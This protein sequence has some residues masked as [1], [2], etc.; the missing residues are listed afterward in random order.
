MRQVARGEPQDVD[1]LRPEE[2]DA[3]PP[4]LRAEDPGQVLL[5]GRQYLVAVHAP[6]LTSPFDATS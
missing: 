5:D 1:P 3:G 2:V 6:N 4:G